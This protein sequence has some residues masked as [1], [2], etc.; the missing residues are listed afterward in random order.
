MHLSPPRAWGEET[1]SEALL[2]RAYSL[3]PTGKSINRGEM[4]VVAVGRR[5]ARLV[6]QSGTQRSAHRWERAWP[7]DP[8]AG[9]VLLRFASAKKKGPFHCQH[10]LHIAPSFSFHL[11]L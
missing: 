7:T 11:S 1:Q 10:S 3:S 4:G 2:Q 6:L 9:G 8:A 5:A